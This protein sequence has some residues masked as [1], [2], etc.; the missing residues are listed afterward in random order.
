MEN[1]I[2]SDYTKYDSSGSYGDLTI[3]LNLGPNSMLG[4]K[5]EWSVETTEASVNTQKLTLEVG[6]TVL[7]TIETSKFSEDLLNQEVYI[8]SLGSSC[9]KG[10]VAEVTQG[11]YKA[12]LSMIGTLDTPIVN[13]ESEEE[14]EQPEQE[15]SNNTESGTTDVEFCANNLFLYDYHSKVDLNLATPFEEDVYGKIKKVYKEFSGSKLAVEIKADRELQ[16]SYWY[17]KNESTS[18]ENMD[19]IP[20]ERVNHMVLFE[21]SLP[22]VTAMNFS[23]KVVFEITKNNFGDDTILVQVDNETSELYGVEKGCY[24]LEFAGDLSGYTFNDY[25]QTEFIDNEINISILSPYSVPSPT[26]TPTPTA[27]PTATPTPTITPTPT[28]TDT[29]GTYVE[30]P[31]KQSE[32]GLR[33]YMGWYGVCGYNCRPFD[34]TTTSVRSKIFRVFQINE[35]NDNY[36]IFNTSFD[37]KHDKYYQDFNEL[38]CG[39][40]YLIVLKE[41]SGTLI[42]PGFV[43]AKKLSEDVG[44]LT[45]KCVTDYDDSDVVEDEVVPVQDCCDGMNMETSTIE[46]GSSYEL[47]DKNLVS[48]TS[49]MAGKLCWKELTGDPVGV[50]VDYDVPVE[51]DGGLFSAGGL[52]LQIGYALNDSNNLFRFNSADGDC[53]EVKLENPSGVNYLKKLND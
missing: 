19:S 4:F 52:T 27:T 5:P 2:P 24:L 11:Q 17:N 36:S 10:V 7:A 49:T 41:G 46:K 3:S 25:M 18:Y 12:E 39:H 40:P 53:Y 31:L 20:L 32:D 23:E 9:F 8:L 38:E 51:T 28:P 30:V 1:C 22:D 48:G 37:P 42:I 43:E 47:V 14:E 45:R 50:A 21:Q 44:R 16:L 26:P 35:Q 34:L 13:E 29:I 33:F 6:G 15:D